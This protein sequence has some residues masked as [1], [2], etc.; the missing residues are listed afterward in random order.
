MDYKLSFGL[1]IPLG[2]GLSVWVEEG[3][4]GKNVRSQKKIKKNC[5][6]KNNFGP[7]HFV[8]TKMF[9]DLTFLGHGDIH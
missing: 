4:L 6:S 2:K 8:D 3:G 7:K 1:P 9:W 5:G